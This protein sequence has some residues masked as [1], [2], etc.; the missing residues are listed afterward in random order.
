MMIQTKSCFI[1]T[2]GGF[3][4]AFATILTDTG[5]GFCQ[6]LIPFFCSLSPLNE[7]FCTITGLET[8]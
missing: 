3:V 7:Q 2:A 1:C 6:E 4:G 5:K 8:C